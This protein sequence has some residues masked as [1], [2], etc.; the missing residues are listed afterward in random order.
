MPFFS[1]IFDTARANARYKDEALDLVGAASGHTTPGWS[2]AQLWSTTATQWSAAAWDPNNQTYSK[3]SQLWSTT[4]QQWKADFDTKVTALAAMTTDRNAWQTNANTA[5]V[6]NVWGSGSTWQ[7][8]YFSTEALRVAAVNAQYVN[9]AGSGQTWQAKDGV[10]L[11]NYNA[12]VVLYNDMVGQRNAWQV[13]ANT[14]YTS[15]AWASGESWQAAYNR[16]LPVGL[17]VLSTS[18]TANV[19][20]GSESGVMQVTATITGRWAVYFLG[21]AAGTGMGHHWWIAVNSTHVTDNT[22]DASGSNNFDADIGAGWNGTVNNGNVI[23]VRAALDTSD[24][25]TGSL[26]A[27]FVPTQ[28]NP[29]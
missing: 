13:N 26:F 16:V 19:R 24:T 6:S 1:L 20:T 29:H 8:S 22:A 15:G 4:A 21:H 12:E 2:S 18:G 5:Y 10:D 14:A 17:T 23:E 11:A 7:A 25:F 27:V 3:A 9:N 28:A